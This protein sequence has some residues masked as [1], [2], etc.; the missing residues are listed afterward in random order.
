MNCFPSAFC[1]DVGRTPTALALQGQ[2][3]MGSG[4]MR[5]GANYT[6]RGISY[7]WAIWVVREPCF[8][9]LRDAISNWSDRFGTSVSV[10]WS[11]LK[12]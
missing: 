4:W 1:P 3:R 8:G 9:G 10:Q 12:V 7:R 6:L 11:G 5:F 2:T